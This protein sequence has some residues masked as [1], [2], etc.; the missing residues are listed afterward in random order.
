MAIS[1]KLLNSNRGYFAN[2]SLWTG[3]ANDVKADANRVD[4]FGHLWG[5]RGNSASPGTYWDKCSCRESSFW[6]QT[7][8][9]PEQQSSENALIS[10]FIP[11]PTYRMGPELGSG[12]LYGV[13]SLHFRA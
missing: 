8:D 4:F 9:P 7:N 5:F 12:G 13:N 11:D 3:E 1:L 2:Q 6:Y 10:K